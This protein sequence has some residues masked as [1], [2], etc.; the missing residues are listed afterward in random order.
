MSPQNDDLPGPQRPGPESEYAAGV[1]ELG[2]LAI[3]LTDDTEADGL[4]TDDDAVAANGIADALDEVELDEDG[5][6]DGVVRPGRAVRELNQALRDFLQP[7]A[8]LVRNTQPDEIQGNL[9]Q[10]GPVTRGATEYRLFVKRGLLRRYGWLLQARPAGDDGEYANVAAGGIDVGSVVR[11]GRGTVGVDLDALGDV[12]PTVAARGKIL[13]A[14]AH[15]PAGTVL[16]YGLKDFTRDAEDTTPIDAA[17]QGV[18]LAGGY[19]RVRVAFYG[20]LPETATEAE[21]L[22]LA[23]VRNHRGDGGRADLLITGGDIAAGTIWIASECWDAGLAS[24]YRIVR[25]CPG[26]GVGGERCEVLSSTGEPSTCLP[27]LR[28][29]ELPPQDPEEHLDDAES[30]D[31]DLTAPETMPDGEAP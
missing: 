11:R 8:A 2:A 19:N 23:R 9:A 14:F 25:E 15:N 1:P 12:D 28:Q 4:A 29:P 22:V 21:E 26:D 7:I 10:W 31:A 6:A 16:A 5:A 3:A 30:P 18:H 17:F 27:D 20:N 24:V 13:G